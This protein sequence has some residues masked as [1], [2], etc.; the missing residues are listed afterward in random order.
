MQIQDNLRVIDIVNKQAPEALI[1]SLDA[2]KAFDSVSHEYIRKML[3]EFGLANF[4]PIFDI[5]YEHQKVNIAVNG[6]LLEGY[7]IKNGVKQGDSLSCILF[8]MCMD[9]LIRNI[10]NNNSIERLE[11]NDL[12]VPKIVAYADDVSCLINN[13]INSLQMVFRE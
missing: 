13:D 4:V 7:E 2:R 12:P 10:E 8:I 9:P 11:I 3:C 1:V 6:N 5:L